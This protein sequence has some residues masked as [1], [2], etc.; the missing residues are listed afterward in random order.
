MLGLTLAACLLGDTDVSLADVI[1]MPDDD[2]SIVYAV[3]EHSHGA[4]LFVEVA[5]NHT[6]SD[7]GQATI[8]VQRIQG[9]RGASRLSEPESVAECS[10][11]AGGPISIL[12]DLDGD[13]WP[14]A[15]AVGTGDLPALLSSFPCSV[16]SAAWSVD[17]PDGLTWAVGPMGNDALLLGF[18]HGNEPSEFEGASFWL[19]G[20]LPATETLMVEEADLSL[21]STLTFSHRGTTAELSGDGVRDA[22]VCASD[23]SSDYCWLAEHEAAGTLGTEMAWFTDDPNER[24]LY[25]AWFHPPPLAV[26]DANADGQDDIV[27]GRDRDF[28]LAGAAYLF[29]GPLGVEAQTGD[30]DAVLRGESP[31]DRAG[32]AVASAGDFDRDGDEELLVGAPQDPLS[33]DSEGAV[34]L[35]KGPISEDRDLDTAEIRF[36][37]SIARDGYPSGLGTNVV[38][39]GDLNGDKFDDVALVAN[40]AERLDGERPS[41]AEGL[42]LVYI[43]FGR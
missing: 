16:E 21:S 30:A 26:I 34:Y 4:S 13:G 5:A 29:F 40:G 35:V 41:G 9:V 11:A 23:D 28:D 27:L 17:S 15:A 33:D 7:F 14:E 25:F 38:G 32:F 2:D 20:D 19:A 6:D 37:G 24:E 43:F 3:G 42:G 8:G 39:P 1:L 10:L 18:Q 36:F 12:G 31:G 22:V